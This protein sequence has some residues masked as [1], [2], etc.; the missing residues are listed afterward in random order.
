MP[1]LADS[2]V[3][4]GKRT[5]MDA[6][7]LADHWGG[8]PGGRWNGCQV[9]YG[10]TGTC[11]YQTVCFVLH[12]FM[13]YL[14]VCLTEEA[15]FF[16]TDSLFIK[17]PGRS[18]KEAFEFG[19]EFCNAVTASNP[20]PVQLKLEKVYLGSIL[21]TVSMNTASCCFGFSLFF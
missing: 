5:L 8:K 20:A 10:D 9:L 4:C 3:E 16:P 18:V 11:F 7:N 2:I 15:Y 13:S 1:V 12:S 14:E 17:L 19:E 6:I 21:Q